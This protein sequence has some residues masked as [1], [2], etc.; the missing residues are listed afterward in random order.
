MS[1]NKKRSLTCIVCPRGCQLEVTLNGAGGVLSVTGNA[2]KR[3]VGYA[4]AECTRPM[5]TVTST[6]RCEGGKIIP[7]KT[8]PEV[9]KADIF[10]VMKEINTTLAPRGLKLGDVIIH[11]VAGTGADVVATADGED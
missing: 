4:E 9:P 3:G 10:K 7:V 1:E 11:N 6:M 8:L 2:C 5:R